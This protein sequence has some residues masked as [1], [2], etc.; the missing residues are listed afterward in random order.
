MM[1]AY[2]LASIPNHPV[3]AKLYSK[4][5]SLDTT[6]ISYL[7]WSCITLHSCVI[8]ASVILQFL[9]STETLAPT[10]WMW[11]YTYGPQMIC[12]LPDFQ[13]FVI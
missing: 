9:L 3:I 6:G 11:F 8:F 5:V 12:K 13:I 1:P 2:G 4:Q 7:L 10:L